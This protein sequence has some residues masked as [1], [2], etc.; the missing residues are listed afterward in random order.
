M[1]VSNKTIEIKDTRNMD[2]YW[3]ST[4]VLDEYTSKIGVIGFALY[5]AY[6]I[7]AKDSFL[8]SEE[9]VAEKLRISMRTLKKYKRILEEYGLIKVGREGNKEIIYIIL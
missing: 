1:K 5:L 2:W 3:V 7:Y 9:K 4:R 6:V 8:P